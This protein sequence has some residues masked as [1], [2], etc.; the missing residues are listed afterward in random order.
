MSRDE[1]LGGGHGV[2]SKRRIDLAA[3]R[4]SLA[5]RIKVP[6]PVRASGERPGSGAEFSAVATPV[7]TGTVHRPLQRVREEIGRAPLWRG[8]TWINARLQRCR[9]TPGSPS[10]DDDSG[11]GNPVTLGQGLDRMRVSEAIGRADCCPHLES[12]E[13]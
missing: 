3:C 10:D 9:L 13:L 4:P 2:H 11:N 6:R 1:S 12:Q 7:E 5:G 8:S